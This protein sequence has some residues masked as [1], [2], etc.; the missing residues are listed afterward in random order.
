MVID[1]SHATIPQIRAMWGVREAGLLLG[2]SKTA[3]VIFQSA[4]SV[5]DKWA[6]V[7]AA[8]RGEQLYNDKKA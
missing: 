7:F 6:V 1:E 8:Q 4:E 3:Y 2:A 5:Q